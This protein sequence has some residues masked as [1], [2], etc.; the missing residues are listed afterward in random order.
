MAV[1]LLHVAGERFEAVAEH[2]RQFAR[3]HAR[4]AGDGANLIDVQ[5]QVAQAL[6]RFRPFGYES[7]KG[8]FAFAEVFRRVACGK[9]APG[10]EIETGQNE[11]RGCV[12]YFST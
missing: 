8:A 6:F 1:E 9:I 7:G 11:F 2:V 12:S 5:L 4:T 3:R 10:I